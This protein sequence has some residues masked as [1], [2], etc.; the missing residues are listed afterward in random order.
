MYLLL[1]MQLEFWKI[2]YN[3]ITSNKEITHYH[4]TSQNV[5][6]FQTRSSWPAYNCLTVL[7][8]NS[9]IALEGILDH[10]GGLDNLV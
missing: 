6:V 4:H 3:N 7:G 1:H 10:K 9:P 5:F 2:E 8:I